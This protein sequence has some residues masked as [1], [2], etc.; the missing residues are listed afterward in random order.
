MRAV[1]TVTGLPFMRLAGGLMLLVGALTG[2]CS[3]GDSGAAQSS[4]TC[5]GGPSHMRLCLKTANDAVEAKLSGG[6]SIP[7]WRLVLYA[8]R[9]PQKGWRAIWSCKVHQTPCGFWVPS[10]GAPKPTRIYAAV[11]GLSSGV[12]VRT[13]DVP[14][15]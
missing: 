14:V 3:C 8:E 12:S 7:G 2:L 4:R 13:R 9:P 1:K 6:R 10:V 11:I 5:A 15:H